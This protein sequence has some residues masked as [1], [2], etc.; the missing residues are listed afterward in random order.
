[1]DPMNHV[2]IQP[3]HACGR[4]LQH[5]E[6]I[7]AGHCRQKETVMHDGGFLN[8]QLLC[9]G[10]CGQ[11]IQKL[12]C[13]NRAGTRTPKGCP[14]MLAAIR[15]RYGNTNQSALSQLKD[16]VKF[17]IIQNIVS[18]NYIHRLKEVDGK[19]LASSANG[20]GSTRKNVEKEARFLGLHRL[21]ALQKLLSSNRGHDWSGLMQ[22]KA[23]T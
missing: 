4:V 6:A 16:M 1:M 21:Q 18:M 20:H 17:G 8:G 11:T 3:C 22:W 13:S 10:V 12:R 2:G 5:N 14:A 15:C 23:R 7:V 9:S 19:L